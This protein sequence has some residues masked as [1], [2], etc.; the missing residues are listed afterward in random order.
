MA[1]R[2]LQRKQNQITQ[3]YKAAHKAVD[4]VGYKSSLD[5][6]IAHSDGVVVWVQTGQ[7][8]NKLSTGNK[9]YGNAVKI[10]HGNGYETLYAHLSTVYVIN[11]QTVKKGDLVGYMGNT[12]RSFGAHL[13]FEVRKN[14]VKINPTDY[15]E[16]DLPKPNT[17]EPKAKYKAYGK[18]WYAE[19]TDYNENNSDGYA[20]IQGVP[21]KAFAVKSTKGTIK[22]RAH[23]LGGNWTEWVDE[24]DT[25]KSSGYAGNKKKQIDALQ[26]KLVDCDG[27][28]AKYRVSS[29]A[30]KGW[31]GWCENC[32]NECG[33]GYAGVFGKPIDCV[34]IDIVKG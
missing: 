21:M 34:Q 13:H 10:D 12:G 6:I 14:G 30:T 4:I 28:V 11:G 33:D 32:Q 16:N 24:Y 18:K 23:L 15:L 8:N 1:S 2:V 22:Y 3:K 26:M 20:G 19:V 29:T 25:S 7:K 27:Y 31:Y 17:V 9:S 5:Y